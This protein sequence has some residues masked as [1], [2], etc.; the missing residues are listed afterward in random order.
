MLATGGL[1]EGGRHL[2][3]GQRLP[4]PITTPHPP[5]VASGPRAFIDRSEGGIHAEKQQ[6][7]VIS[8]LIS[9]ILVVSGTVNLQFQGKFVSISLRPVLGIVEAYVMGTEVDIM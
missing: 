8:G 7:L 4:F 5:L 1:G 6:S 2:S 9:V 3:K